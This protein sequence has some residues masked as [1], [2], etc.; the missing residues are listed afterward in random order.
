MA[1]AGSIR[2]SGCYGMW[3]TWLTVTPVEVNFV[4]PGD[5]KR[6]PVS[7]LTQVKEHLDQIPSGRDSVNIIVDYLNPVNVTF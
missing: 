5:K 7:L 3:V 6:C 2:D 1:L 4:T